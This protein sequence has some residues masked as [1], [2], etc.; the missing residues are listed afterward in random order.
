MAR[1]LPFTAKAPPATSTPRNVLLLELSLDR[2]ATLIF[3]E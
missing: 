2:R 3:G 1:Y